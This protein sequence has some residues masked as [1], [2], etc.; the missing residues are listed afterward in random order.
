MGPLLGAIHWAV[1]IDPVYDSSLRR[2]SIL[3]TEDSDFA[4]DGDDKSAT[5]K[6]SE[7]RKKKLIYH[8]WQIF[9]G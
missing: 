5:G 8:C 7:D 9:T 6:M 1:T 4:P 3:E 2:S